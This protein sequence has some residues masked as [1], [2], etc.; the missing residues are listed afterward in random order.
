MLFD[1]E[2][3]EPTRD[4]G[5]DP[6]R[7]RTAIEEIIR[8]T[9]ARYEP[10]TWWPTP[11]LDVEPG[12]ADVPSTSLYFGA[13]GVIWALR[14]LGAAID[15]DL[16][17]LLEDNRTWLCANGFEHDAGSYLMGDTGIELLA[18]NHDRL[19]EL[20]A[21][22]RE[23]PARELMWG[24]PGTMLAALFLHE[25]TGEERWAD[26]FRATAATLW[27][28]LER[29]P[30][31]HW[32]QDMYGRRF[33]F[34]DSVHGFTATASVLI[35]GRA[36]LKDWPA[37]EQVISETV[38]GTAVRE[39][40]QANWPPEVRG[41]TT[42]IVQFCHGAP[43]FVICL[44]DLPGHDLDELLIAAGETTWAAGPVA[45]GPSLCHGT[46]GNGYAFLRLHARTGDELWLERARTFAMHAIAQS[47]EAAERQGH[48][49]HSLWTGDLG[50]AV[51]LRACIDVDA[52]FPTL[53]TF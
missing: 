33:T 7:A 2:R 16:S 22:N 52:R 13:A 23:H 25:R 5:W 14:E 46:A 9:H 29:D 41:S 48:R 32:T 3:H 44:G 31:P 21:A 36:L 50:L 35:R 49:R 15:A 17:T 19:A 45:K 42:L 1:P 53:D 8:D 27:S 26:L 38:A 24:S 39:G 11:P 20:I 34:L 28:Q 37:W 10:R 51:Y 18:S 6:V 40:A 30:V 4:S 12:D 43:G 47:D